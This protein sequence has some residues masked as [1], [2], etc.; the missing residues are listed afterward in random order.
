MNGAP[1]GKY[2][3]S[4]TAFGFSVATALITYSVTVTSSFSTVQQRIALAE[5][6]INNLRDQVNTLESRYYEIRRELD[7]QGR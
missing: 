4:L 7:R 3:L 5:Y 6:Q 2:R 1:N